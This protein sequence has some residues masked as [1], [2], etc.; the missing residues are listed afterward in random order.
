MT[1]TVFWRRWTA[2]PADDLKTARPDAVRSI[3]AAVRERSGRKELLV[4]GAL[5]LAGYD[6]PLAKDL[7]GERS[8]PH[9][10]PTPVPAGE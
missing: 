8:R 5:E 2:P 7:V 3:H 6:R 4:A 9:L 10:I 1:R